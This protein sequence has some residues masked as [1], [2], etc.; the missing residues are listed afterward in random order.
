MNRQFLK[1]LFGWGFLLWLVGYVL[2]ILLVAVVAPALVGWIILPIG[3]ALTWWVLMRKVHRETLE[4]FLIL[5]A[6][7]A[8]IAVVLDYVLIVKAFHPADGYYKLDVYVYYVLTVLLPVLAFG[9]KS[10]NRLR[11]A[12]ASPG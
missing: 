11:R 3:I 6:A 1:E 4:Q 2:G 9:Q 12:D 7:W 10:R 8:A 5:G